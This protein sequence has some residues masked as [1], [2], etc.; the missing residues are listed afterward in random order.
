MKRFGVIGNPVQ[1]S[2]SPRIHQAFARQ[3]GFAMTYEKVACEDDAF[4]ETARRFFDAGGAGLN[5]TLPFKVRAAAWAT[6]TVDDAAA[7]GAVNTIARDGERMVGYNTDGVGLVADLQRIGAD[8]PQAR[9]LMLGA[10]GAA[11]GVLPALLRAG[12]AGVTVANRTASRAQDL[13]NH[14]GEARVV[15]CGLAEINGPFDLVINATSSGVQGERVMLA[16]RVVRD[17]VCYDMMYGPGALFHRWALD[18]GCESHDGL[19]M[20]VGQAAAAFHIWWGERP[21]TEPVLRRL[22]ETR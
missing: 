9:I 13:A 6:E 16:E 12:I 11:L 20:L 3:T 5:V 19:G 2:L 22:R 18:L 15:G 17:A 4:E 1:H 21:D 7:A 8:L 10:G 14:L